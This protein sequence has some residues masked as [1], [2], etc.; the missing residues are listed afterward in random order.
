MKKLTNT[1]REYRTLSIGS[2]IWGVFHML[3]GHGTRAVWLSTSG[4]CLCGHLPHVWPS[5][6]QQC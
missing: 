4:R 1:A 5:A 6:C 2:E 3:L